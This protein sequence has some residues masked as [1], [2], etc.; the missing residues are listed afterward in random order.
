MAVLERAR[1]AF[2]R[3]PSADRGLVPFLFARDLI[4]FSANCLNA[5]CLSKD[6][7]LDLPLPSSLDFG[8]I[9]PSSCFLIAFDCET[10]IS[11]EGRLG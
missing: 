2:P 5:C 6:F 8:M 3:F 4:L 7:S 10:E 9:A 1:V 11:T